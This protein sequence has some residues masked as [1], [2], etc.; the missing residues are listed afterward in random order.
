MSRFGWGEGSSER[1]KPSLRPERVGGRAGR[2]IWPHFLRPLWISVSDRQFG[3]PLPLPPVA[4]DPAQTGGKAGSA[5]RRVNPEG[6]LTGSFPK[7]LWVKN[8]NT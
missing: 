3:R 1:R 6:T 2:Q 8:A 4:A 7:L 5:L